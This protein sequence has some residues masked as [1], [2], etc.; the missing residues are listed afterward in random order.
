MTVHIIKLCVGADSL[1][2]L[3]DWHVWQ[4]DQRRRAGLDPRPVCDTRSTPKRKTE[5][6]GVGSLYWVIKGMITVRQPIEDLWTI[7][8]EG[9]SSR[10]EIVLG[11]DYVPVM[12]RRH[13]PFQGWRY[14]TP[15]DAP[16]DVSTATGGAD[17]PDGLREQLRELGAW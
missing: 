9:G 13:K 16:P 12:P 5:I 2:D 11:R 6:V 15:T 10:C 17:L 7:T 1:Q 8:S 3:I 4:T 14:L